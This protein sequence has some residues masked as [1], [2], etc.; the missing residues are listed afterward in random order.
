MTARNRA[1]TGG[2]EGGVVDV[3]NLSFQ[4]FR[5]KNL[6]VGVCRSSH[7]A[8]EPFGSHDEDFGAVLHWYVQHSLDTCNLFFE[9]RSD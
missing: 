6:L 1:L 8:M 7:D 2:D 5:I 4:H 3:P 9:A